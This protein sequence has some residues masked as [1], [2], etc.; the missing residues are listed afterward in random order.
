MLVIHILP[1]LVPALQGLW[2]LIG[3][4]QH[5]SIFKYL[6]AD[7][8][9]FVGGVRDNGLRFRESSYYTVI[10][11]IKSH[12]VMDISGGN[13]GFQGLQN[14]SMLTPPPTRRT[15]ST[16]WSTGWTQW[17]HTTSGW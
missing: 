6:F 5:S 17:R 2:T 16:T 9:S 14:K 3:G 7:V 8:W 11:L 10:D 13:D 4:G 12:A 15:A 1:P